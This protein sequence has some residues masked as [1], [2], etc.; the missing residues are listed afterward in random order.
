MQPMNQQMWAQAMHG[1]Y[2]ATSHPRRIRL[3]SRSAL[4]PKH[5]SHTHWRDI[6]SRDFQQRQAACLACHA[7]PSS[8]VGAQMGGAKTLA[9][10]T[11]RLGRNA[12]RRACSS[13]G[14][15]GLHSEA[16]RRV[17]CAE[18]QQQGRE[19]AGD[20]GLGVVRM[21]HG[22]QVRNTLD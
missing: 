21:E 8:P 15:P 20:A 13:S 2:S 18:W 4:L 14:R 1:Q 5:T 12:G 7:V 10:L 9:V 11:L 22:R 19:W 16:G 6:R 3:S 17:H